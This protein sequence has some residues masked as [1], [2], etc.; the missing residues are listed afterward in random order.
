MNTLV[1][2]IGIGVEVT[3]Q[4]VVHVNSL[5]GRKLRTTAILGAA[6]TRKTGQR[7]P[8][9]FLKLRICSNAAELAPYQT[10][11]HDSRNMAVIACKMTYDSSSCVNVNPSRGSGPD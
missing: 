3:E 11:P 10:A 2:G 1:S 7:D 4:F 5:P 9:L 6:V 8:D